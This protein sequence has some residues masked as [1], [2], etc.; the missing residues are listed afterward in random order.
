MT[1]LKTTSTVTVPTGSTVV[2]DPGSAYQ[3]QAVNTGAVTLC[4]AA[5]DQERG[6]GVVLT[7][8]PTPLGSRGPVMGLQDS[9]DYPDDGVSN[10]FLAPGQTRRVFP[11]AAS[12]TAFNGSATTAG[13]L[14][15]TVW[16]A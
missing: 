14:N 16:S 6:Q 5:N 1:T 15:L 7:T 3:I 10:V 12:I 2:L 4:I 11:T 13:Q 8:S 9:E